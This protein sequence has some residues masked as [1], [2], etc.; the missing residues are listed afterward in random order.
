MKKFKPKNHYGQCLHCGECCKSVMV[1]VWCPLKGEERVED[2]FLW[3]GLHEKVEVVRKVKKDLY[4][5]RF[6]VKCEELGEGNICKIHPDHPMICKEESGSWI[7][8]GCG[9]RKR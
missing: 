1:L 6:F 4:E 7:I 5:V 3:L 2:Y 9:F 8:K